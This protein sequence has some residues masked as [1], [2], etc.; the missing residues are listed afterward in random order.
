MASD[1][2]RSLSPLAFSCDVDAAGMPEARVGADELVVRR[3]DEHAQ[4]DAAAVAVEL[5]GRHLADLDAPEVHRRADVERADVACAQQEL[6]ARGV[7]RDDGRHL[8]AL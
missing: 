7:A 6:P 2:V 4:R 1:C 8:Q 5:V 3:V